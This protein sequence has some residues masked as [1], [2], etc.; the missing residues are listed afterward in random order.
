MMNLK[1]NRTLTRSDFDHEILVQTRWGDMDALGHLNHAKYLTYME[2]ARVHYY[3]SMGFGELRHEQNPG[4][5]LG[6]M[7]IDYIS[8]VT[9][10]TSLTVCHRINR[11][12]TKSFD[13]LG[14]IFQ[15]DNDHPV[16]TGLF[17]IITFDYKNNRTVD[18][19][20][21]IAKNLHSQ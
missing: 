3:S 2:N 14:A 20:V 11:V 21:E 6:G 9:H 8:Q 18:V 13:Y 17:H 4:L 10:P 5:I 12:G 16:C 1:E 15:E 19:P 7:T